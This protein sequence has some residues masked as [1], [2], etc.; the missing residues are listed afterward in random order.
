MSCSVV[1]KQ[2]YKARAAPSTPG[3][4][5]RHL[6]YIATRPGAV[7][8]PGCGFGLWGRLPGDNSIRTQNDLERAKRI[9]RAAS[10]DHTL[11]RAIVSVG[12]NDAEN[13][14]LYDRGRWEQLVNN[15][16]QVIA[17]NMNIKPEDLCWCASMHYAN[18]HPHVHILYWD[19]SAE[20]RQEFISKEIFQQKTER[21]RAAFAGAIHREEIQ[22]LQREQEEQTKALRTAVQAMCREANPEK[23]LDLPRLYRSDRLNGL[24]KHLAEL[25]QQL[26]TKGSLRYA[27]LPPEYKEKVNAL[28][29]KCLKVPELEKE[30]A[31]YVSD[32]AKV[33]Q[34]YANGAD[35]IEAA[36]EKAKK[37]LYTQ[38]GNEVMGVL[39]QLKTEIKATPPEGR[40]EA[41]EF[42][43]EIVGEAAPVLKAYQELLAEIPLRGISSRTGDY[44]ESVNRVIE[45][46]FSDPR[47]RLRLQEYAVREAGID[48]SAKENAPRK[49]AGEN[50]PGEKSPRIL[51]GKILSDREWE[52]YRTQLRGIKKE[53]QDALTRD[54]LGNLR[55]GLF[56]DETVRE[57]L[58]DDVADIVAKV[59]P[60]LDTYQELKALLPPE[61]VPVRSME[62]QIKGY[63]T[64]MNAVVGTVLMDARARIRVQAYA[65]ELAGI[66]LEQLP[67]AERE[68]SAQRQEPA[69]VL[70]G[71]ELSD[72]EWEDYQAAYREAKQEIRSAVTRLLRDDA[73]WTEES[74]Q[75]GSAMLVCGM[76]RLLSQASHQQKSAAALMAR[77]NRMAMSKDRS[78]EARR[79]AWATQESASEWG[80]D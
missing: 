45:V 71:K 28:I 80:D 4:N 12:K 64:A 50:Q 29:D 70:Y 33:A 13:K 7:Y 37:E 52:D 55:T 79:D 34:L 53:L 10:A 76:L 77:S 54:V 46:L 20:P 67:A 47:I 27:Y 65:L 68:P 66:N 18:R 42:L 6:Q 72:R 24:A 49:K 3:L 17:K 38:L 22:E 19:N 63:Y 57:K 40:T 21:I 25:I 23:A 39:R 48:L 9:V 78:R 61:R 11:Y 56:Q 44:R 59:V 75:T 36:V 73:G 69:H 74:V 26:P 14:G 30:L 51:N 2:S 41:L 16:I 32:T 62:H 1:F 43:E 58:R 35:S 31:A 60:T 8:N 5:V 15:Q